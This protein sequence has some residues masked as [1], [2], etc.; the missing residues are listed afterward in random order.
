MIVKVSQF[1]GVVD[2]LAPTCNRNL[3]TLVWDW[4][5]PLLKARW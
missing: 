5:D 4:N 2:S 1:S 3:V